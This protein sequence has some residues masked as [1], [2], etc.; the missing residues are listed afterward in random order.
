METSASCLPP[1]A[2]YCVT[3]GEGTLGAGVDNDS[4]AL[5]CGDGSVGLDR[6]VGDEGGAVA[7][8]EPVLRVRESGRDVSLVCDWLCELCGGPEIL[9]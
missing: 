2:G 9:I 8:A 6:R 7:C 3:V 1:S 4:V 5:L